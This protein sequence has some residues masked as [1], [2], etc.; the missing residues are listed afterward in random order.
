MK[1]I[2]KI[3][4][5]GV[6]CACAFALAGCAATGDEGNSSA[7]SGVATY[8]DIDNMDFE[9]TDRDKRDT[10]DDATATK[11]L[12]AGDS[13]TCEGDGVSVEGSTATINAEGTYVVT[14]ELADGQLKVNIGDSE[15]AQIVLAGATIHNEDGAAVFVEKAD[16][17]FITLAEGSTN[18]LTDGANYV[19]AEGEDEP[20][21][22]LFSKDD[23]TINGTG[24]LNVTSAYEHGIYSKDDLVITGGTYNVT[25]VE[26]GIRGKDSL[27][28]LDG[29]FTVDSGED[30]LK[31]SRDDDPT[32]GFVSIDGG[33]FTL[34]AGDD[35]IHGETYL[36][37]TAGN[38]DVKK[39]EEGLEAM[40]VQVD[41]GDIHVVS[42]DDAMNASAPSD[43]SSTAGG[44]GMGEPGNMQ[45]FERDLEDLEGQDG[46]LEPPR[47]DMP[48]G[49]MSDKKG[50][51]GQQGQGNQSDSTQNGMQSASMQTTDLKEQNLQGVD[52]DKGQAPDMQNGQR[53]D[54][55]QPGELPEG[56]AP[57]DLPE[58]M[59]GERPDDGRFDSDK[60][61][62]MGGMDPDGG[63]ENCK[64]IINGGTITL[65]AKGDAIDSNG[66]LEING[67]T[68]YVTGPTSGGD[69]ALDYALDAQCNGG[70][71]LIVG[72][73]GMAQNFSGGTQAYTMVQVKG[74]ADQQVSVV[75]SSGKA[76]VS[77]TPTAAFET[78]IVSTPD[79]HSNQSYTLKVGNST[80]TITPTTK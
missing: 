13:I 52:H 17:C 73:S 7:E 65:E 34:N 57:G 51:P 43:A 31:S 53:P 45:A 3:A 62:G 46:A 2:H 18:T 8:A 14:G 30:A 37:V 69:G 44:E 11:I 21:A 5:F 76:L 4:T 26:D 9:Y 42:N 50:A 59:N 72:S 16:K 29:T 33:T 71:V 80:T 70:T 32:R 54:R 38:I 23:L 77:Y 60:M 12:L 64:I 68:V 35:A 6:S 22:T 20:N 25:A 63:D 48:N 66:S 10:Y 75:D 79:F 24:T 36:R 78:V 61:G 47:G 27:K 58:D 74:S 41:A 67:G 1:L 28:I 40:V 55:S 15:K 39:C 19:F 56:E 49:D